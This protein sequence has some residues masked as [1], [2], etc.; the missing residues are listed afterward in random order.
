MS[1][2]ANAAGA[3]FHTVSAVPEMIGPSICCDFG[4]ILASST[5]RIFCH[6]EDG[7]DQKRFIAKPTSFA[8]AFLGPHEDRLDIRLSEA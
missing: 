1:R 4:A 3:Y 7:P 6:V 8:E 5:M 2:V